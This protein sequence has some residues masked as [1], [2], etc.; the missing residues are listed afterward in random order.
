MYLD[1]GRPLVDS[2][3]NLDSSALKYSL[4]APAVTAVFIGVT[5]RTLKLLQVPSDSS[6]VT[7]QKLLNC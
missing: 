1:F 3:A 4:I 5:W 7:R 6:E 2:P